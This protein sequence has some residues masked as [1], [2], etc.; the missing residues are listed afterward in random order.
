MDLQTSLEAL[1]CVWAQI[2]V[3]R[4]DAEGS[5]TLPRD[6]RET[7]GARLTPVVPTRVGQVL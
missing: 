2:W 6:G 3:Q 5:R 4:Q 1:G 7:Q